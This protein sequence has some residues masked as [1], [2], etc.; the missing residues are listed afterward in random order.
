MKIKLAPG[1]VMCSRPQQIKEVQ[2]FEIPKGEVEK[3]AEVIQVGP[4]VSFWYRILLWNTFGWNP[5]CHLRPGDL[6]VPPASTGQLHEDMMFLRY[7]EIPM[8]WR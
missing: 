4:P 1:R 6:I 5:E 2:G 7:S 3:R 8:S